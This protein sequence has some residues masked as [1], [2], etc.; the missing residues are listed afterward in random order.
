MIDAMRKAF[1]WQCLWFAAFW[2]FALSARAEAPAFSSE[3]QAVTHAS[4]LDVNVISSVGTSGNASF[5]VGAFLGA[6]TYYKNTITGQNTIVYNL[7]AG[8]IWNGHESL[9]H[10]T[11]FTESI[12]AYGSSIAD[13]YDRHATWVGML[14]G[15]RQTSLE[16]SIKQQGIAYGT[17]LRSAAVATA[18]SGSAYSLSFTIS[19]NSYVTAFTD[20][21]SQADVINSSFGY[22]DK[23][24]TQTFTVFS[25]A[26]V[27]LNPNATYV[28]SAGN[29]GPTSNTVG[30]PGA[31]Y[32]TITVGAL[33]DANNYDSVSSFSSRGPQD[34]SYYLGGS[35]VTVL[36]AR[37]PI[38]ISA[39]GQGLVSAF[40]GGQTGGN[41]PS[42]SGS[43]NL[44]TNPSAYSTSLAG[45]SF[46]A[47]I[48]AGGAALV[49][50]AAKTLPILENNSEA[51]NSL[52]VKALLMTGADKTAGWTNGQT[53]VN[54]VITTNQS[55]DYAVGAGRMNLDNTYRIQVEG[56]A[57]VSG[58]SAGTLSHVQE[59]GW[60]FAEARIG[61]NNEYVIYNPLVANT[62]FTTTL[63][64]HRMR[65]WDSSTGLL[66][67]IAQADMNL[68][69]WKLNSDYSFQTLVAESVSLYNPTEHL[70]LIIPETAYYGLRVSYGGN[71]FDNSEIWGTS[72]FEQTYGL[73]WSGEAITTLYWSSAEGSGVWN[74]ANATWS[75][76]PSSGT[77]RSDTTI[78]SNLAFTTGNGTITVEGARSARSITL[79]GGDTTFAGNA[80][81]SIALGS[82]GLTLSS[83]LS[84]NVSIHSSVTTIIEGSQTWTNNSSK[85]LTVRGTLT[86]TGNLTKEGAGKVIIQGN[87]TLSGNITVA[88]GELAADGF[89]QGNTIIVQERASLSGNG[90]LGGLIIE[91]GGTISPGNSPGMLTVTGDATW[92]GGA[93]YNW[94][95]YSANADVNDQSR[96]GLAWDFIDIG[97]T[98]TLSGLAAAPF[99]INLWT[100]I[101]A[102]PDINGPLPDYDPIIGSTWL[103]ASARGGINLDGL[104]LN[105]NWDYSYL[106]NLN[107][108]AT[109]GTFGW[110]GQLPVF[111]I[112]T[113]QDAHSLYL[114]A[115]GGSVA[116]PEPRQ[117]AAAIFLLLLGGV[118]I[119][120]KRHRACMRD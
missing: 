17:D 42:L 35:V 113:L 72:G 101:G 100:L 28:T 26:L 27:A 29:S 52:V 23:G 103:I 50:S 44:G 76:A 104:N 79:D 73:A 83:G 92:L 90:S 95:V 61:L 47:P 32:N 1:L 10:V 70:S 81:A 39:P 58:S 62:N 117:I 14:I 86:G 63:A 107:T 111:Q 120:L 85:A 96:A 21:F 3:L 105:T 118:H 15:G 64:W 4:D 119:L 68:S 30:A 8:H 24:G 22:A 65:D 56:Q 6:D 53:L 108:I 88:E 18:W 114:Y 98:L 78:N 60:D 110:A 55:L 89:L 75:T 41:N 13:L 7:E 54:G 48:V 9:S 84:G 77:A 11:Q 115:I 45:T 49:G 94:Q 80:S 37:A 109:N 102:N 71:T 40:Y 66:Y 87:S 69:L 12:D 31:G 36:N 106:F 82:G 16:G 116:V 97:G 46:S 20:A 67:E 43:T 93:H 74:G 57:S 38:D 2:I 25:D 51:T 112:R 91:T 5:N 59:R 34:F 33:G 99:N 19:N